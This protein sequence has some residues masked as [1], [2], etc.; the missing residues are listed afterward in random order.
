MGIVVISSDVEELAILADRVLVMR[1]GR[2]SGELT[3][4]DITEARII[5]LSYHDADTPRGELERTATPHRD[6]ARP[7]ADRPE[8]LRPDVPVALRH[9]LRA[10]ADDRAVLDH[11]ADH[12]LLARQRLNILSQAS[13]T[14]IIAAGLT[15]TLVVG[16]FDLSVGFVA[17]FIGLIVVGFMST[18]ACRSG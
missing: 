11:G 10:A 16:E 3:G 18:R 5:E 15:Y 8:T 6:R 1:E 12:V 2:L 17:S 13:L 9:D 7:Q 14:A 4:A